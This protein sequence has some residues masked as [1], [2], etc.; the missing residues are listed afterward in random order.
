MNNKPPQQEPFNETYRVIKLLGEGSFGKAYLVEENIS[1]V[2]LKN[3]FLIPLFFR[4][5]L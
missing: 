2:L 4:K 3:F 1:H 5:N